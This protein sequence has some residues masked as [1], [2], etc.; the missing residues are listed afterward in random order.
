MCTHGGHQ[1]H[2]KKKNVT[3]ERRRL[4][5]DEITKKEIAELEREISVFQKLSK[6]LLT[7]HN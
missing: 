4:E 2:A 6:P 1:E 7:S 5:L 3:A